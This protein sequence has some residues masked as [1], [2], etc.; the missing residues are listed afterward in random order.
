[1]SVLHGPPA[2]IWLQ[3]HGDDERDPSATVD[4]DNVSWCS[5][6]VWP[7]DYC[8]IRA[9]VST[10]KAVECAYARGVQSVIETLSFLRSATKRGQF[11]FEEFREQAEKSADEL[12]AQYAKEK[13][14]NDE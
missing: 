8:Y 14:A 1:M 11:E 2:Q 9:S 3:F 13:G 10:Q 6:R 5:D 7:S 4:E 12:I